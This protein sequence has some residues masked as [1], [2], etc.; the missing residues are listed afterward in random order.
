MKLV[1]T[2]ALLEL[3]PLSLKQAQPTTRL[4]VLLIKN[5][6]IVTAYLKG[7]TYKYKGTVF[8]GLKLVSNHLFMTMLANARLYYV[9]LL[10]T[11]ALYSIPLFSNNFLSV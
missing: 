5:P 2:V 6:V 4:L 10:L 3:L 9:I 1:M 11:K 7:L 8:K